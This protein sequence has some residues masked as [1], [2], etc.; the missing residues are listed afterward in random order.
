MPT[1]PFDNTF[2]RLPDRFYRRTSPTK[3]RAPRMLVWNRALADELG[4][5]AEALAPCVREV[6]ASAA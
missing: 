4:I 2:A 6:V 5:D 1:F 3:L